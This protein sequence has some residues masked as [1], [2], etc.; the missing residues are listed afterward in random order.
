ME[1]SLGLLAL[2]ISH[3]QYNAGIYF[4]LRYAGAYTMDV[5]AS[6]CFNIDVDSKND[7]NNIFVQ[8]TK[9]LFN[10]SIFN[11]KLILFGK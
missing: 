11:P 3:V 6:T 9:R 8:M 10:F 5:I 4:L 2:Q 7:R 1:F